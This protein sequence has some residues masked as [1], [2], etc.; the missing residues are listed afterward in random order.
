MPTTSIHITEQLQDWISQKVASGDYNNAS[1]VIRE[2]LRQFKSNDEKDQ[3]ELM[4]LRENIARGYRQ[5]EAGQFSERTVED[6]LS[7]ALSA[8]DDD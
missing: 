3:L 6:I 1:E 8:R 7:D 5:A 2:A 4:V